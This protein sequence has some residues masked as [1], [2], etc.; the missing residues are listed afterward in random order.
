MAKGEQENKAKTVKKEYIIHLGREKRCH[1]GYSSA[2]RGAYITPQARL[3]LETNNVFVTLLKY[4]RFISFDHSQWNHE[5]LRMTRFTDLSIGKFQENLNIFFG[6]NSLLLS[7]FAFISA[8]SRL[9]VD[10]VYRDRRL[11]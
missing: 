2:D 4:F 9:I 3:H 6:H 1:L 10:M 11:K 7:F 5:L 8:A